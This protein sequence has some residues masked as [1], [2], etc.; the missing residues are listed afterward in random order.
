MR[1]FIRA[2][3]FAVVSTV[4][5]VV[6]GCGGNGTLNCTIGTEIT[7]S[8]ASATI[9]H[10]ATPPANQVQFIGVGTYFVTE[11]GEHCAVP[12]LAWIAYG[13]WSNPDPTDIT[14]SSAQNSTNGTAVCMAPTNGAV[15]LTGTF[16]AAENPPQSVTK[17][18]QL[19]C[20]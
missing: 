9:N 15:T 14:I 4:A 17:S 12:A 13:T 7:V 8:P 1:T 20:E 10:A 16:P 3:L 11:P 18:V 5:V 19:T 6:C 2:G